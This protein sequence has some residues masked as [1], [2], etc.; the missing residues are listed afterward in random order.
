MQKIELKKSEKKSITLEVMEKTLTQIY[1]FGFKGEG[2]QGER[3]P[4]GD[5]H[6]GTKL[7]APSGAFYE[8]PQTQ[9]TAIMNELIRQGMLN[10]D[11]SVTPKGANYCLECGYKWIDSSRS[12]VFNDGCIH[13]ISYYETTPTEPEERGKACIKDP[14]Y[15]LMPKITPKRRPPLEWKINC[16]CCGEVKVVLKKRRQEDELVQCPKCGYETWELSAANDLAYREEVLEEPTGLK[17]YYSPFG[18]WRWI[19]SGEIVPDYIT[20]K[21]KH[22]G[23]I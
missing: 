15:E 6:C 12:T 1:W 9:R 19:N 10:N 21:H 8:K 23:D 17:Y 7:R 5:G 18:V 4:Y 20:K 13:W 11:F 14:T 2:M 22:Y 16:P 3:S